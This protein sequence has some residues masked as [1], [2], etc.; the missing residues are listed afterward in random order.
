MQEKI[1]TAKGSQHHGFKILSLHVIFVIPLSNFELY[2]DKALFLSFKGSNVTMY[3]TLFLVPYIKI[4]LCTSWQVKLRRQLPGFNLINGYFRAR[5]KLSNILLT[6][7]K[8]ATPSSSLVEFE[9]TNGSSGEIEF[10]YYDL[11]FQL[12]LEMIGF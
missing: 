1:Y 8:L 10:I 11:Q 2:K 5:D 4:Y 9:L 3:A 7:V 12:A 6:L